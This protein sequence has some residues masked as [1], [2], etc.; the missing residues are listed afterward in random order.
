MA[1]SVFEQV[2]K[3]QERLRVLAQEPQTGV[4]KIRWNGTAV[5]FADWIYHAWRRGQIRAGTESA[6]FQMAS[7]HFCQ[8]DGRPF[9]ARSLQV[10]RKSREDFKK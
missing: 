3:E 6:A 8:K 5:D 10:S 2:M 4:E 7:Q 9:K 1:Y